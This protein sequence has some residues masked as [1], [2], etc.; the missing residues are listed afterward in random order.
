MSKYTSLTLKRVN[1]TELWRGSLGEFAK[2]KTLREEK[3]TVLQ[4]VTVQLEPIMCHV[5]SP[6]K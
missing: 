6:F 1:S 5:L 4:I 2:M 3:T